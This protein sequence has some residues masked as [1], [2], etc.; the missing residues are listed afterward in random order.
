MS[1]LALLGV[2]SR[3]EVQR[4]QFRAKAAMRAQVAIQG[5][6]LGG[7]PP[8][9]YALVDA[10]PHP[11]TARARWGRRLLRLEPDPVTAPVVR[12]IFEQR[13][14]GYSVG[15]IT[16]Q[17]NE[18]GVPCPSA[19]WRSTASSSSTAGRRGWPG[20]TTAAGDVPGKHKTPPNRTASMHFG[21]V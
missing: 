1:L 10:G 5:R 9:G 15:W 19:A 13:L 14:A 20:S 21:G 2:H 16:R 11:N 7:R 4:A 6:H 3:R 18:H 12:W 8:Y 17:L